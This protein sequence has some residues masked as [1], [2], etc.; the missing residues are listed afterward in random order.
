MTLHDQ[1]SDG[2]PK[3]PD[4]CS[5]VDDVTLSLRATTP[6][7]APLLL[8]IY[9]STRLSELE[10][11]P[12]DESQKRAL[13]KMQFEA[14]QQQ[15]REAYSGAVSSIILRR[16]QPIGTMLVDKQE[17]DIA[18]VDIALLPE[19]RNAG[20][21]TQLVKALMNE[22]A[23]GGKIVWLHVLATSAAVRFYERLGF[24]KTGDDGTYLEMTWQPAR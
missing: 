1:A 10:F 4:K 20:L 22:A 5:A 19:H 17:R 7:D 16:G 3:T 21:G 8:E 9:A 23:S 12:W 18:L 14:R 6:D 15:Y 2:G 13:I 24:K 11:V